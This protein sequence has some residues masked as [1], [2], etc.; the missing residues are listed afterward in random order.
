MNTRKEPRSVTVVGGGLIGLCSAYYLRQGGHSVTVVER[1]QVGGGASR[2]NA[3]EI[4]P[5]LV[6]PLPA[7]G[8]IGP[9]LRTLHHQDSALSIRPQLD[10]ALVRFLLAFTRNANRR[11][12]AS[13]A[14][15]LSRLA[16]GTFG[17]F[18]EL[19]A[20]GVDGEAKKNGFLFAFNSESTARAGLRAFRDLGAPVEARGLLAQ[21]DLLDREP[22]LGAGARAGFL[23]ENQRC[24]DPS[25]FVD[26]LVAELRA[27]G[28]EIVEGARVT[29][30]EERDG[31]TRVHS[32][33]GDFDADTALIAAG[34]WT[35]EVCRRLGVDLNL[36][37][38][39]GYSFSVDT[40][41]LPDRLVHLSDA[42]VVFT[43]MGK[44]LR[45]A[46]T[47]EF[48]RDPDR[49]RERRIA[50][51]VAAARP[52]LNGADWDNRHD[53]WVGARVLTPDGLP[54]IGRLPGRSNVLVASGHNLLGLMLGPAT[55]RLVADFVAG[56]ED[57]ELRA[58]LSPTRIARRTQR[59]GRF[60][61]GHG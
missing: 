36:F 38:G 24:L 37:P 31:P 25:L 9:A 28:V 8:V 43:P 5:D 50:A 14:A 20:A 27:Q 44:R 32:S 12:Y 4:C 13:G 29:S 33:V 21:A 53:E 39:K 22:S 18:D 52:Y 60:R 11:R 48:E 61:I 17:L 56:K 2:G 58:A 51:I 55:G 54:V 7:P 10:P 23:V 3:G 57:P 46:G 41:E 6:A 45:V 15:A 42:R 1:G 47:M 26:R 19:E 16:A 49:F 30:V 34:I 35:R 40:D 59:G